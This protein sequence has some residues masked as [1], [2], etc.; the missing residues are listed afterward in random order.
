[1]NYISIVTREYGQ[2]RIT[3][4]SDYM[5]GYRSGH[6]KG[7]VILWRKILE[8]TGQRKTYETVKIAVISSLNINYSSKLYD[9]S[10][11]VIEELTL[12]QL[13]ILESET[14]N[15]FDLLYFIGT[16]EAV[17]PTLKT[18]IKNFV[19]NGGGVLIEVP[20]YSGEIAVISEIDSIVVESIQRP[21]I[22][23]AYWTDDGRNSYIY[24]SNARFSTMVSIPFS[25]F[26]GD[27]KIWMSDVETRYSDQSADSRS[28]IAK[29]PH[30]SGFNVA[31][32]I[33]LKD[34]VILIEEGSDSSESSSETSSLSSVSIG[35]STSSS[36][37][38]QIE[39]WSICDSIVA[40]WPMNDFRANSVVSD[41]ALN[42]YNMAFLKRGSDFINTRD[43]SVEGIIGTSNSN[44]QLIYFKNDSFA[45]THENNYLNFNNG[46]NDLEFGVSFWVKPETISESVFVCKKDVWEIGID[47]SNKVYF[48]RIDN[49]GGH[50]KTY[51]DSYVVENK[52][53]F[54]T[55]NSNADMTYFYINMAEQDVSIDD[56]EYS[57]KNTKITK[58]IIGSNGDVF[59][60][61]YLDKV[62]II[63]RFYTDIE[64]QSL[65]NQGVSTSN[66]EGI[67]Y[68]TSSSSS[69]S[70]TSESS[71]SS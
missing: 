63:D 6:G 56:S 49:N 14:L 35:L 69:S 20:S 64:I 12:Q 11:V 23:T 57:G 66:C 10:P 31:T 46:K 32:G 3:L 45:E 50:L 70:S 13:A 55:I 38:S 44:V 25:S 33:Y 51:L 37:S 4:S 21:D 65:Y 40:N 24:T 47:S 19:E 26:S 15:S 41:D 27:W 62:V 52:W 28:L 59:F 60:N 34:G 36:S 18:G 2:G 9:L 61:G 58:T 22:N 30:V 71:S 5:S 1:M 16:P 48:K 8:W 54:I 42:L 43:E 17:D 68:H 39:D 67:F 53:I 7:S 29:T